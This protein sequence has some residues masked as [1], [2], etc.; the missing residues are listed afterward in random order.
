MTKALFDVQSPS[1]HFGL[2]ITDST[3]GDI[4]E[5]PV[6]GASTHGINFIDPILFGNEVLFRGDDAGGQAGIWE[7][8]G[9]SAGT[10]ELQVSGVSP[11]LGLNPGLF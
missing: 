3:S 1:G 7:T 8:D 10:F 5:L 4:Y 2:W 9:T 11:Q 6:S